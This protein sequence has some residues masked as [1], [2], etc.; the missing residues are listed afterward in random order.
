M[1]KQG[2]FP[3]GAADAA[4]PGYLG[5]V[6]LSAVFAMATLPGSVTKVTGGRWAPPLHHRRTSASGQNGTLV[7]QY[8]VGLPS[9]DIVNA[10]PTKHRQAS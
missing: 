10:R 5:A 2:N 6:A 1:T 8:V 9:R 3:I 4:Q 7:S